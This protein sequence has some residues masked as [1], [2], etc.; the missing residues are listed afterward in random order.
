MTQL[1][2]SYPLSRF[3]F[4]HYFHLIHLDG[5]GDK[6][7]FMAIAKKMVQMMRVEQGRSRLHIRDLSQNRLEIKCDMPLNVVT[8]INF[9]V[10]LK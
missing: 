8:M 10:Q 6:K 5:Y 7:K 4:I 1:M 2:I 3:K 9:V